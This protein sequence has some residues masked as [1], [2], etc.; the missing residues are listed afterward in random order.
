MSVAISIAGSGSVSD[1]DI[2][3][4]SMGGT[5]SSQVQSCIRDKIRGWRFPSSSVSSGTYGFSFN[6]TR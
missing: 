1:V 2:T 6:F 4:G 5:G 3:G